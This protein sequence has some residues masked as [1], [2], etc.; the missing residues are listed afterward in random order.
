[1]VDR[2]NRRTKTQEILPSPTQLVRCLSMEVIGR[3]YIGVDDVSYGITI[4]EILASTV[5]LGIGSVL[6]RPRRSLARPIPKL[7]GGTNLASCRQPTILVSITVL[8]YSWT[9][10]KSECRI[11]IP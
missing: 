9:C 5:L 3:C 8:L 6:E 10:Y 4:S 11:C 7:A 2:G 1:M